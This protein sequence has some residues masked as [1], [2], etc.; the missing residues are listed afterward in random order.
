MAYGG[1]KDM[2]AAAHARGVEADRDWSRN[3][4]APSSSPFET[5]KKLKPVSSGLY[6]SSGPGAYSAIERPAKRAD[7]PSGDSPHTSTDDV[8][9]W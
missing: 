2:L 8:G 7:E 1:W 4:G 6:V 9:S 5:V 3:P